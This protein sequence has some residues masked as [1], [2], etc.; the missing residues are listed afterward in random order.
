MTITGRSLVYALVADPVE[1]VRTPEL[2]NELF[3]RRGLDVVVVPVH[4]APGE[5]AEAVTFF[6]SWRNLVGVGVTIPHKESMPGLVDELTPEA[7]RCAASNVVRRDDD[8]RL[9]GTQMDGPGFG[10]SLSG[11]GHEVAGGRVL[12]A[13]AGGTA[14]AIAFELADR[15]VRHLHLTNRTIRRAQDLA[16]DVRQAF[17]ALTVEADA[18]PSGEFDLIVN[19][20]SLGMREED[21]LPIDRELLRPGTVVADVVMRPRETRLLSEAA[22]RGCPT[23]HGIRMLEAQFEATVD[24]LRLAQPAASGQPAD[25]VA[26]AAR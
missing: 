20:T 3:R 26:G 5:L 15:G 21:P 18:R 24:F 6:R 8:G 16:E 25:P 10:W 22:R 4:V 19:A 13:G 9:V 17:P 23:H 11:A 2:Y 12:I 14:R 1:H 7:T